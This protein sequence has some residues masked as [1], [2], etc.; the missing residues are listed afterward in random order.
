MKKQVLLLVA[1][2]AMLLFGCNTNTEQKA[3]NQTHDDGAHQ[4]KPAKDSAEAKRVTI[5]EGAIHGDFNHD[6]VL[7]YAWLKTPTVDDENMSCVGDCVSYITFSDPSIP[8]IEVQ[9]C[10]SGVPDNLG[11]L[12]KDGAD[13]IGLL[14]GWFTS[15][16]H[17]YLVWTLKENKWIY[18]VEP[19]STHCDQWEKGIKPIEVDYN[20]PGHVLIRYSEL[21]DVDLEVKTKSVPV[22]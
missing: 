2:L 13:E 5:P 11:D 14:P 6:G 4:H 8:E 12:N 7:D 21:T 17:S 18:A 1:A 10:I 9:D 20:N 3:E 16:W 19:F 15:C 22:Q